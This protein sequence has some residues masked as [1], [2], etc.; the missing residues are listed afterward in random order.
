[1]EAA[2]T[3]ASGPKSPSYQRYRVMWPLVPAMAMVMIDFTIVS[4]SVTTIQKDLSL[5]ATGAQW[6]VTAYA[7]ATAAVI[8]LGGRLGDII[9]HKRIVA[10]GVAVF[11]VASLLC[12]LTPDTGSVAEPWLIVFRTVQG[13]GGALLIPSTTVLVLNSF[14]PDERGKGL[15]LFFIVAGL[16]TAIGPIAGSY[17]TEYWTWRAIFWINVPVAIFALAEM[18]LVSLA[19]VRQP[20]RIDWRGAFLLVVGLGLTV[21]GIQEST[22]WGW[23]S[24]A[25]IGS[26]AVGLVVLVV[27]CVVE[28]RTDGPIID[29]GAM[30]RNRP[31]FVDTVVIFL[32][33]SVWIA[34]FFFGSMYFQIAVGQPP[35]RAGFSILTV[36]YPFF[37]T[38]RIGGVMLDRVGAKVPTVVGLLV[39]AVGMGIWAYELPDLSHSD[40]LVGMLVTGAGLGLVMSPVNTDALNRFGLR[41]RGEA[42]GVVQTARNFGSAVG[43]AV[44]GTIVLTVQ[45]DRI[46]DLLHKFGL[47]TGRADAIAEKILQSG[48]RVADQAGQAAGPIGEAVG[49]TFQQGF[50][51]ACQSAFAAGGAI[52]FVAFLVALAFMQPGRETATE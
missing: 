19:D 29:V 44:L 17:L 31:F 46:E 18:R 49:H 6:T 25:T 34:I 45:Q 2:T 7:L 13:V 1:M 28:A 20:G 38:S 27:F 47:P 50:A 40:T 48:S 8:A 14:P 12:G 33:F 9:G 43:V 22:A 21:L 39:T 23:G 5:S 15:S 30:V 16:F 35:S 37:A 36:F 52:M 42:S 4:I 26:I 51:D 24:P 3:S 41:Q 32:F 11:A 10:V